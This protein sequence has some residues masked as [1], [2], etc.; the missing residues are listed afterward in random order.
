MMK[1]MASVP[2][3]I[4]LVKNVRGMCKAGG[5]GLT[6]FVSNSKELLMSIP[7]KDRRQEA[8]DKRLLETS[9]DNERA[10]GALCNI[11][12][13]KLGFQVHMKEK[14]LTRRGMLLSLSSIYD[15]LGLAVPFMIEVRRIIQSLCH[16]NLDWDEQIPESMARQWAAWKSNLLLLEDIKVE[17]C[18]KPKKL[19]KITEYS[20]HHFSDASDYGYGQCS[21]FQLVDENDQIH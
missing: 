6:K 8:P 15:P 17:R 21:Y 10:L 12:D 5:F 7:Q 9:P 3:A 19:G 2:E 14:P 18:L 1:S 4:T 16:Q 13:D 20:L 11:E